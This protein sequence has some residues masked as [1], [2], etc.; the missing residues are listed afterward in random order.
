MFTPPSL[1]KY[2][3]ELITQNSSC[4]FF[5]CHLKTMI[6]QRHIPTTGFPCL[7]TYGS[8]KI[9]LNFSS[10]CLTTNHGPK[11]FCFGGKIIAGRS[12]VLFYACILVHIYAV[13]IKRKSV[14]FVM[15]FFGCVHLFT[16]TLNAVQLTSEFRYFNAYLKLF[17]SSHIREY[18]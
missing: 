8:C 11:V 3:L 13:S 9:I 2:P 10:F 1:T 16:Q 15:F 7:R 12:I 6:H 5:Y 18:R 14:Y 17:L 4:I